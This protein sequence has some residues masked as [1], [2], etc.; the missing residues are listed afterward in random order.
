MVFTVLTGTTSDAN[1]QTSVRVL[2]SRGEAEAEKDSILGYQ[3]NGIAI[4]AELLLHPSSIPD[5]WYRFHVKVG[6][7]L[8]FP[9]TD[10]GFIRCATDQPRPMSSEIWN[11]EPSQGFRNLV[12]TPADTI[13]RI[14]A[15]PWWEQDERVV[16]FR[17]RVDGV[18]K[19]I[20][21]PETLYKKWGKHSLCASSCGCSTPKDSI[22]TSEP[23]AILQVSDFIRHQYHHMTYMGGP[24]NSGEGL[25]Q[26]GGDE[27]ARVLCLALSG[28]YHSIVIVGCLDG[29]TNRGY[30]GLV[31]L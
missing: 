30:R 31:L 4:I 9:L 27:A 15:E 2:G 10:G 20:F 23:L 13:I 12:K 25:V 11:V 5:R 19:A 14:D 26:T 18:V 7:I 29:F 6:Q 21:S 16:V 24:A 22:Q 17:A 28:F 1:L 8:D 3:K